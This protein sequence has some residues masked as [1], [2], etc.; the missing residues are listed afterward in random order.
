MK[1][2]ST[3]YEIAFNYIARKT[4]GAIA[5]LHNLVLSVAWRETILAQTY[6]L[7]PFVYI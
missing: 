5:S 1:I 3:Y 2:M 7:Y 4:F 6:I